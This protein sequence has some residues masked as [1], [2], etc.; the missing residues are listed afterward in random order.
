MAKYKKAQVDVEKEEEAPLKEK[1][2]VEFSAE[3]YDPFKELEI[4]R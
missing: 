1:S 3:E 2:S 4:L